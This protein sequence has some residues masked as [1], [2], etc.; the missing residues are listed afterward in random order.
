MRSVS[1]P[2]R[3]VERAQQQRERIL[4]AA[5]QCFV[6]HGFHAATM[7]EIAD[8]AAISAG[9]IYRYFPNKSS[10]VLAIIQ[11]QLESSC[12]EI[13]QLHGAPDIA[14]AIFD[15]YQRWR[16]D[17]PLVMNAALFLETT[18]EATRDPLIAQALHESDQKIR[19][20]LI[21][22]LSAGVDEGGK[23]LPVANAQMAALSLQCFI[24]G[25]AIRALR[26]PDVPLPVVKRMIDQF[27]Q[28]LF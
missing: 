27:M 6:K 16:D 18:A 21:N 15:V 2:A 13:R 8:T 26:A 20:E 3:S 5:R 28:A 14:T 12:E 22:W 19:Q 23:G 17:S 24:E 10:I 7:A 4:N 9:L 25:L 1:P 11:H